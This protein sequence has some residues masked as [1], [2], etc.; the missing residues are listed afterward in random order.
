VEFHSP[1]RLAPTLWREVAPANLR[2]I[3]ILM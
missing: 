2:A 3:H 1:M